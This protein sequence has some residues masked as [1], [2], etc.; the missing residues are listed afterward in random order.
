M[1]NSNYRIYLRKIRFYISPY[2]II[3]RYLLKD[4]Q[5]TI[6]EFEFK[7]QIIDIGCGE[8]PYKNLFNK[9]RYKGIDFRNYSINKDYPRDKPDY[10]FDDDYSKNF[11]LPFDDISFENA[12]AF[13]VLEHH[14][15][16]NVLLSELNRILKKDGLLMLSVPFIEG[17]HESPY[18][19]QRFTKYG[20]I[21][22]ANSNGFEVL[23]IKSQGNL[24]S[25]LYFLLAETINNYAAGGKIQYYFFGML[26]LIILLPIQ[27]L[28]LIFDRLVKFDNVVINYLL[29]AR[30][31]HAI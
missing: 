21:R 31:T 22:L 20:L 3:K 29:V 7:G 17:I 4:I 2:F 6:S 14:A 19:Y 27:Y 30:K 18:D 25:T 16:P 24:F 13:Q 8:M 11:I 1:L 9:A 5:T 15:T 28:C 23:S 10:Y 26:Y 12:V